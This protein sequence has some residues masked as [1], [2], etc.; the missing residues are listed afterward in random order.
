MKTPYKITILVWACNI[1][2]VI[3]TV[4]MIFGTVYYFKMPGLIN[5]LSQF[6]HTAQESQSTF[7]FSQKLLSDNY[8]FERRVG[9]AKNKEEALFYFASANKLYQISL[10]DSIQLPA[11]KINRELRPEESSFAG[12][13]S[14]SIVVSQPA[15]PKPIRFAAPAVPLSS[16]DFISYARADVLLITVGLLF[17]ML[18]IW[19]LRK[20]ITGLREPGF[21]T[22]Q[23][24]TNLKIA[25]CAAIA[26]PLFYAAWQY[27]VRPDLFEN[28]QFAGATEISTASGVPLIIFFFGLLL[29]VVAWCFD[30]GV[31][32]QKEQE[33]TI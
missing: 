18:F 21:F 27:W 20:F 17:G 24:S 23:N 26:A 6:E 2:L 31:K 22:S 32:L 10:N 12:F 7:Q 29:L 25:S 13:T 28:Y 19:F 14:K 1:M 5:N 33:L 30:Q 9:S 8:I 15:A 3:M 16:E 4:A 11:N